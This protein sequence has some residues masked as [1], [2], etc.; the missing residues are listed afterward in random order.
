MRQRYMLIQKCTALRSTMYLLQPTLEKQHSLAQKYPSVVF[1]SRMVKSILVRPKYCLCNEEL[2]ATV[3][4]I[5][6]LNMELDLHVHS[7]TH[8][9]RPRNPPPPIPRIWAHIR[10]R[11]WSAKTDDISLWP[12]WLHY[13][14]GVRLCWPVSER[15]REWE[16]GRGQVA[17]SVHDG[18]ERWDGVMGW[19]WAVWYRGW[20]H[21][22]ITEIPW[23][24]ITSYIAQLTSPPPPSP[25][26]I[27]RVLGK[28][29]YLSIPSHR[30]SPQSKELTR[31]PPELVQHF[32]L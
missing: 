18:W 3:Y 6:R 31:G 28:Q 17:V 22:S 16:W 4:C 5:H 24:G 2:D 30:L 29:I 27:L 12:P 23:E 26:P 21:S 9:L 8:W 19:H 10:G 13:F 20:P 7:C 25:P 1:L 32:R 14:T 15:R 11:Y